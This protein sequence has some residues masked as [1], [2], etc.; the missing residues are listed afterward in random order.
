VKWTGEF[1]IPA[2]LWQVGV[3]IY[4]GHGGNSCPDGHDPYHEQ[5]EEYGWDDE[6]EVECGE[7]LQDTPA[8]PG[9]HDRHGNTVL[10]IVDKGGV[11]HMPVNW[12]RCPNAADPDIQLLDMG[13]FPSSF[14][15]IK[16]AFTFQ[17]LDDF[18]LDNLECK[19]SAHH[20]YMKLR[21]LTSNAFPHTVPVRLPCFLIWLLAH[22]DMILT[23]QI[24]GTHAHQPAVERF[25][26]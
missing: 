5:D 1:F 2:W 24:P 7:G 6:T 4:L 23:G 11:H 18:L 26:S 22:D 15:R 16:T 20:Y 21:R 8:S 19:T 14:K 13:L 10:L 3:V 17:V 9:Q 12:C 25:E